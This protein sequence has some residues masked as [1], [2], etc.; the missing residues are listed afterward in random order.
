MVGEKDNR[1]SWETGYTEAINKL[2]EEISKYIEDK[3]LRFLTVGE[4]ICKY[5]KTEV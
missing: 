3:R 2:T 1:I 5:G 4:D